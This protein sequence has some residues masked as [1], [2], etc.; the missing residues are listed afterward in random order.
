LLLKYVITINATS[1]GVTPSIAILPFVE[2]DACDDDND[3]EVISALHEVRTFKQPSIEKDE[4][5]QS[6]ETK[7]QGREVALSCHVIVMSTNIYK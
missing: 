4:S 6:K 3:V 2:D 5:D 1:F 7:G